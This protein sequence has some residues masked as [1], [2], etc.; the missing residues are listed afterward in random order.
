MMFK[1]I[2]KKRYEALIAE[3]EIL[4]KEIECMVAERN[5]IATNHVCHEVF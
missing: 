3:N 4:H 1:I 2:S 5:D